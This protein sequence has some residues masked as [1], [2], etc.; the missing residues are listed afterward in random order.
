MFRSPAAVGKIDAKSCLEVGQE[1]I[2]EPEEE[3]IVFRQGYKSNDLRG[4]YTQK[5]TAGPKKNSTVSLQL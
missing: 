2:T 1:P 5:K 3:K 4:L